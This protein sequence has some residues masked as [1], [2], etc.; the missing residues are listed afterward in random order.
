MAQD[1]EPTHVVTGFLLRDDLPGGDQI[2]LV[3]RSDRVRTYRGA[4]A[5]ISGYLEPGVT[6]LDQMYTELHEEAALERSDV[7]LLRTG[8]PLSVHDEQIGTDWVVHPFLFLL[9][10]PEAVRTDWE[11][12]DH[13]WVRP[14]EVASYQTVPRL[15]DALATVYSGERDR[16]G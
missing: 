11:A 13:R 3:R 5:G 14:D 15:I 4:W 2:L 16:D 10:R 12:T 6:P 9:A 1:R 8:E 7:R